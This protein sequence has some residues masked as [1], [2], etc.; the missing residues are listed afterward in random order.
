M[1]RV[2][3]G[4]LT[5]LLIGALSFWRW[6]RLAGR[7]A[8]VA[9]WLPKGRRRPAPK[10]RGRGFR[11]PTRCRAVPEPPVD[12][13][14]CGGFQRAVFAGGG[15]YVDHLQLS[16]AP[17]RLSTTA[18]SSLFFVYLIGL[19]VTPAAG[20]LITRI[21]LRVGIAGAIVLSMAGVLLTLSSSLLVVILGLALVSGS[22]YCANGGTEPPARG[23]TSGSQG[24]RG[25]ALHELL[26]LWRDGGRRG[27]RSILEDGKWPACAVFIV[28]MQAVALGIA[29]VGWRPS[30]TSIPPSGQIDEPQ[31]GQ[32]ESIGR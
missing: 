3:T 19:L 9:A 23:R 8:A 5:D 26:L 22:V 17:F 32:A 21:G 20:F 2:G 16:A 18:L 24:Y 1:G 4:I 30:G 11:F 12:R 15:V 14:V 7:S 28:A 13:H 10:R 31:S 27:A 29:L 25:W 6:E